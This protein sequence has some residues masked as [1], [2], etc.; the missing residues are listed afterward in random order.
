M[1]EE[2]KFRPIPEGVEIT[3]ENAGKILSG[4]LGTKEQQDIAAKLLA[5]SKRKAKPVER[6]PVK[7]AVIKTVKAAPEEE[8]EEVTVLNGR[9][10]ATQEL[11]STTQAET[12]TV[13]NTDVK[14]LTI[15]DISGLTVTPNISKLKTTFTVD[16]V[17]E[18]IKAKTVNNVVSM[19][20]SGK[21]WNITK[22]YFN[23]ADGVSVFAT[24]EDNIISSGGKSVIVNV[25]GDN[26]A[27]YDLVIKDITNTKWYDWE[28]QEFKT[29]YNSIKGVVNETELLLDIPPQ[30][31]ETT[32]HVFFKDIDSTV[33]SSNLPTIKD[34]WV[35]N[36]LPNPTITFKFNSDSG[37]KPNLTTTFTHLPNSILNSGTTN[38][39]KININISTV[40]TRSTMSL[41]EN[42]TNI[43]IIDIGVDD[44]NKIIS[45][46][47]KASVSSDGKTGTISGTII[48][49]QTGHR[50]SDILF[51]PNNYFK[52][53]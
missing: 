50:D 48:L 9:D 8:I 25:S 41:K 35:I 42:A 30:E 51:Y 22:E 5:E 46:D 37:F 15:N 21:V 3:A 39:G 16:F 28:Y 34:P 12:N 49:G 20:N 19:T 7:K 38:D 11:I 23:D 17:V 31:Q 43:R 52:I 53:T 6:K 27:V 33:Y 2:T 18:K 40:L 47:L 14:N 4:G 29:G 10:L 1:A 45:T 26:K 36:Q 13:I 32:Y 24:Q 44:K